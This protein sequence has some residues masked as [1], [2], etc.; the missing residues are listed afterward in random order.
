MSSNILKEFFFSWTAC[1]RSRF[2][3]FSKPC[4]KQ[5]CSH[6]GFVVLL[7]EHRQ[8]RFSIIFK[9]PGILGMVNEHSLQ[10]K[11][12]NY[13]VPNKRVTLSFDALKPS[14]DFSSYALKVLAGIIFQCK[15]V[16]SMNQPLL[17]SDFS[18]AA[19]SPLSAF[20]DW[21]ELEPCSGLTFGSR[22][23]CCYFDLSIPLKLSPYQQ[24]DCFPF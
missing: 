18:S 8:S 12:I 1:L 20:M 10:F 21:S 16:L 6:A 4:H 7:I 13:I 2:K 17:A 22:E 15:T 5:I 11:V 14:S 23:C 24:W 19:S 9:G 3:I